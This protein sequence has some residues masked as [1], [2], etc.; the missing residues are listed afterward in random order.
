MASAPRPTLSRKPGRRPATTTSAPAASER[1]TSRSEG[2]WRSSTML[3]LAPVPGAT[4]PILRRRRSRPGDLHHLGPVVGEEH[5]GHGT[6]HPGGEVEDAEARQRT[7]RRMLPL[8]WTS[9]RRRGRGSLVVLAT[10][11]V[12][13]I[14]RQRRAGG[15]VTAARSRQQSEQGDGDAAAGPRR[16]GRARSVL[17]GG[18]GQ[19]VLRAGGVP[20]ASPHPQRSAGARRAVA[21]RDRALVDV[22]R[23]PLDH[24]GGAPPAG[25]RE[26]GRASARRDG[27]DLR[28]APGTP[29]RR[30][31]P[32]HGAQPVA[33]LEAGRPPGPRRDVDWR[34]GRRP[35][36]S[37]PV[38]APTTTSR[39]CSRCPSGRRVRSRRRR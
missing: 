26:A 37:R 33:R 16:R 5:R 19:A 3:G 20:A 28:R 34:S 7:G 31:D 9:R 22:R 18:T 11:N 30:G 25:R 24:Q 39:R 27:R 17:R 10:L 15:V 23:E 12:R 36:D 8:H 21:S 14:A 6:R 13:G 4:G 35:L 32:R 38:V 29:G 2:S 1:A